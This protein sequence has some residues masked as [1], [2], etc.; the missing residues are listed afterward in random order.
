MGFPHDHQNPFAGI[1]WDE[2]AVYDYFAGP[3][4]YWTRE[5]TYDNVLRKLARSDVE[6]SQWDPNSIMHYSFASGLIQHPAKY[7][8]G[9]HPEPGL[10]PQDIAQVQLFYPPMV[11]EE[12]AELKVFRSVA[13]A[14]PAGGQENFVISPPS[15]R[16][17]TIQTFGTADTVMVLFDDRQGRLAVCGGR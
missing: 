10:S 4:N 1:V 16:A 7:R 11:T 17:Y 6:G 5:T 3:P 13:L 9:L 2:Q 14:L 15:T 8:D 12:H